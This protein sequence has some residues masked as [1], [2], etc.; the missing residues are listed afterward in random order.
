MMKKLFV[1]LFAFAWFFLSFACSTSAIS[2]S[3]ALFDA[4]IIET[5]NIYE[6]YIDLSNDDSTTQNITLLITPRSNYLVSCITFSQKQFEIKPGETKE[7]KIILNTGFC[8][9]A[10]GDHQL[11]IL[12]EVAAKTNACVKIVSMSSI[13]LQFSIEGE[14][15]PMLLLEDFEMP[16]KIEAD[17]DFDFSLIAKNT[18]NVRVGAIPFVDIKKHGVVIH[19]ARGTTEALIDS[20]A[21]RELEFSHNYFLASGDYVASAYVQYFDGR[22]TGIK[23]ISFNVVQGSIQND[24]KKDEDDGNIPSSPGFF[25][26][27]N[28]GAVDDIFIAKQDVVSENY[29]GDDIGIAIVDIKAYIV[30]QNVSVSFSFENMVDSDLDYKLSVTIFDSNGRMV[31]DTEEN[32]IVRAFELK[33]VNNVLS[34]GSDK[35]Y[36]VEVNITYSMGGIE[37]TVQRRIIA[38]EYSSPTG[39]FVYRSSTGIFAVV[40]IFILLYIFNNRKFVPRRKKKSMD[41]ILNKYNNIE[42]NISNVENSIHRLKKK[43]RR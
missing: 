22:I 8:E 15:N 21:I 12:P 14:V 11:I 19:T 17:E 5:N 6:Y 10:P 1:L 32:S 39:L 33:N 13:T 25:D 4:G 16:V 9:L 43:I 2:V 42:R 3:P 27:I 7:I 18:G 36:A 29:T 23:D 40:L 38:K 30:A 24:V 41:A 26:T 31:V 37:K 20:G 34:V 35:T 28:I